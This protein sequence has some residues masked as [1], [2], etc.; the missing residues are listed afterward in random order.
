[1]PTG[2]PRTRKVRLKIQSLT[3]PRL[4]LEARQGRRGGQDVRIMTCER[5]RSILLYY[6]EQCDQCVSVGHLV[7]MDTE[8]EKLGSKCNRSTKGGKKNFH[9]TIRDM[10]SSIITRAFFNLQREVPSHHQGF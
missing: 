5:A 8:G 9:G 3:Q 6:G 10:I 4:E 1:V 7:Q 2:H